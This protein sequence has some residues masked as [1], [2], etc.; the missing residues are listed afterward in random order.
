M[1]YLVLTFIFSWFEYLEKALKL[2]SLPCCP[3]FTSKPKSRHEW[4]VTS[5]LWRIVFLYDVWYIPLPEVW[6]RI[7][8]L[9]QDS[10]SDILVSRGWD[11]NKKW[12]M[13]KGWRVSLLKEVSLDDLLNCSVHGVK[14]HSERDWERSAQEWGIW[15]WYISDIQI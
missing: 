1:F 12:T 10:H 15:C 3:P 4:L 2:F 7:P 9:L 11:Y 14:I 13:E 6:F 5:L 8:I